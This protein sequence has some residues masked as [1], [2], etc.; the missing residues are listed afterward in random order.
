M[1][2]RH[3]AAVARMAWA[4]RTYPPE[5]L[6]GVLAATST[7]FDL[8]VFELFVPLCLGGTAI[9][10]D[11][12]LALPDLPAAGAV[13]LINTVPSA[14]AELARAGAVPGSVRV[15]NLA[16]E[17]LPPEL[18]A[19]LYAL[20][21]IEEVHNLYGPSE[22]TTYS[23]GERV[24]RDVPA[25]AARLAIGRPLDNSRAWVLDAR[26]HPLPAG[27]PGELWLGGEG[28][29]RGYLR[30]PD[31]TADRF[32]PDPFA[33]EPGARLYRT[34]DLARRLPDGRLDFLGR[35]DHQ[36]KVRGFRI[37]LGEIET[38]LAAHPGVAEVAVAAW[39]GGIG[40]AGKSLAAYVVPLPGLAVDAAVLRDHL[41]ERLPAF[42]LPAS[43]TALETLPRTANGKLDRKALPRPEAA[44]PA[45]GGDAPRNPLEELIAA[46]W[47]DLLGR[48]A[49]GIH[50]D[51]FALGGHS[52][53]ATRVVSRLRAELGVELPLRSLFETPTVAGL[54]GRAEAARGGAAS[55]APPLERSPCA[56]DLPLSFAQERL[57]LLDRITPGDPAYNVPLAALCSGPLDPRALAA[58]CGEVVR[59]HEVLRTVFRDGEEGPAQEVRPAAPFSL[60]VIDLAALPAAEREPAALLLAAGEALL[61]FD[62]ARGPMF[63]ASLLHLGAEEHALL[64]T[65][66]HAAADGWSLRVLL[67]ELSALYAARLAGEPSPLPELPLQY[68]DY[69]V[70]QRRWL[71]GAPLDAQLAWWRERLQ[72]PPPPL[73][74]PMACP[75]ESAGRPRG[76]SADLWLSA[77]AAGA[78]RDLGRR[79]GATTFMTLMAALQALLARYTGQTDLCVGAPVAGRTRAETEGLIGLFLNTLA[80]RGDLTGDPTFLTLL[81]RVREATL[82]AY[83]HQ[84]L[85]FEKLVEELQPRR[86][87]RAA[88]LFQ[89]LLNALNFEAGGTGL[90]GALGLAGARVRRLEVPDATAKLDLTLY[91]AEVAEGIAL[92]FQYDASLLAAAQVERMAEHLRTLLDEVARDPGLHL[93]EIP[94][95]PGREPAR[96]LSPVPTPAGWREI[97]P[98]FLAGTIHGRFEEQAAASPDA[99]AIETAD[100]V[101][102]Y[103]DL[104]QASDRAAARIAAAGGGPVVALLLAHG[105]SMVAAML[106]ALKAGAVYVPLDPSFPR[107]RLAAILGDCGAGAILADALH[108]D[109]AR[110]LAAAA[111]ARVIA[112]EDGTATAPPVPAP[113]VPPEAPAYILY[114]SGSTGEPKGVVQSHRNVLHHIRAYVNALRLGPG[115]RL[116]LLASHAF[117]A[118]VMDVYGALL[119]GAA[120][121]P[122]DVRG[123]GT[124][125]VAAWLRR[126]AIT[127]YHSTPT[128]YR[129]VMEAVE[130]EAADVPFPAARLVVLGGERTLAHDLARFRR[131]FPPGA[132]FVNGLGP[133][134]STLALQFFATAEDAVERGTVPVGLPVAD[135]GVSLWNGA[136]EQVATYGVGEIALRGDHLALGYWRR[137]DLTAAAF[138][139][140]PAGEGARAYSTGDLARRL[141]DGNLEFAGRADFQVKVRGQ[142]VELGEIEGALG[143]LSG[144]REAVVVAREDAAGD[145]RL[146]AYLLV[147]EAAAP[148]APAELRRELRLRLPDAM[149]PAD[150][151]PLTAWPLT[152]TGKVDRGALPAPPPEDRSASAVA[153]E[154]APRS[155]AEELLARLWAEVLGVERVGIHDDFFALGGHSLLATQVLSRVRRTLGVEIPLRAVFEAATVAGLAERVNDALRGGALAP[156]ALD[157]LPRPF[158]GGAPLSFAQERLWFLDRL[159]PGSAAYNMPA[160]LRLAGDLD[161]PALQG[162][163]GAIVARHEVLRA[164]FAEVEGAPAQ[165]I[166]PVGGLPL[167]ALDL[168]GLPAARRESEA[169]RLAREE[170]RRPFD[171]ARGP[172]VRARLLRLGEREHLLLLV[173]HHIAGDG[174]SLGVLARE[175]A[176]LY[177][178]LARGEASPLPPLPIQFADFAAWQRAWL[179]GGELER[180]LAWWRERLAGAPAALEL[181]ADRPRPVRLSPRNGSQPL[182]LPAAL[183]ARLRQAGQREGSTLFMVLLAAFQAWLHRL[184]GEEDL[185]VGAPIAGRTRV[186]AEDL[187]GP[188][189]NTLVLRGDLA[190]DPPFRELLARTRE[191]ALAAHAHQDLPFERLVAELRPERALGQ[192]PLF[193]V[194]LVLQ[195]APGGPLRLPDL[196][197]QA[198]PL[199]SGGAKLDLSL[200]ATVDADGGLAGLIEYAADLFDAPTVARLGGHLATLL[201]GAAGRPEL[202]L[203]ALPLL[204]AEE[205]HQLLIE[206]GD[207]AAADDRDGLCLHAILAARAARHP[208]AVAVVS[209]RGELTYGE[210]WD[211]SARLAAFLAARGIG[212][213]SFV[214]LLMDSG[215]GLVVAMLAAMRAGAAFVPLDVEW[216]AARLAAVLEETAGRSGGVVLVDAASPEPPA[217]VPVRVDREAASGPV[218]S[219]A[220]FAA[221]AAD[222]EL[223]LYAI[224]TSGSTGRPKGVVV[225]H[226]G[227]VNRF[228]WME[229]A[230]GAAAA[231]AVLQTT[232]P[233]YDSAVW[234]IFWPLTLGGRTV[235]NPS[236]QGLDPDSVAGLIERHRITMTDFVPAVF[237]RVVERLAAGDEPAARLASLRAVVVGGEEMEPGAAREF[238]RRFPGVHLVN[239]YGPTEASIGCICHPVGEAAGARVPIGRPISNVAALVLDPRGHA[240]PA[241]VPGE[242]SVAGRCVGLGYLGDP[243][244]TGRSFVPNPFAGGVDRARMYRTGDRARWRAD[245]SLE[246]L[247]RIDRQIKIRGVRIEPGEIEAVLREHPW[248]TA[249]AVAPVA[250]AGELRLAAFVTGATESAAPELLGFLRDRLPR[251]LVPAAVVV[252][253]ALPLTPAGKVDRRALARLAPGLDAARP[254]GE[255]VAP[256]TPAEETLA[257]IWAEVLPPARPG[258]AVAIGVFDDF[259]ALGGHSLLALQ[260]ISRVRRAFGVELPVRDLFEAPTVAGLARRLQEEI[261]AGEGGAPPPLVPVGRERELPLSFAQ[262][263]LWFL[264]SLAPDSAL[265]QL[266]LAVRLSGPLD[267]TILARALGAVARRHES[268][269]TAFPAVDGGPVQAVAPAG[270][271]PLPRVDLTGLPAAGREGEA[272][273][274]AER[275]ARR[276]FDLARGPLL[277]ALLL[278]LGEAEHALLV[279]V[280]HTVCDGWSIGLLERELADLYA[281]CS[282]G[283]E[284][285]L[286]ELPVQYADYAVWQREWLAGEVLARKLDGWRRRLEGMPPV[287]ELPADRPRP[288]VQTFRGGRLPVALPAATTAALRAFGRSQGSTPFMTLL[289]GFAALLQRQTGAERLPVG[290]PVANRSAVE[291]ERL[292]GNFANT[293][294]LPL[295]LAGA[296]SF[297]ELAGRVRDAALTAFAHQ[298]LPFELLVESLA[299]RRDLSHNPVF[300]VLFGLHAFPARPARLGALEL[301]PFPVPHGAA[302]FD[303]ALDLVETPEGV[304]GGFE[305]AADLFDAATVARL[306]RHLLTLLEGALEAPEARLPELPVLTRPERQQL[307]REW[308]DTGADEIS[309]RCLHELVE[310]WAERAPE[311]EAVVCGEVRLTYGELDRR[312]DALARTLRGLGVGPEV[313]VGVYV[314]R[315][316]EMVVGLLGILKAGGAYLPLDPAYPAQRLARIL[317]DAAPPVVVTRGGLEAGLPASSARVVRL[318][319]PGAGGGRPRRSRRSREVTPANLAYVIY[320]SGST[321]RPKGVEITHRS[322]VHLME[323]ARRRFGF[324]ERDVWTVFHSFAFDFSVWEIWSALALGGRLVVVP[325]ETAQSPGRFRELLVAERV[326]VLNQT[327]SAVRQ[328]AGPDAAP[329]P[330]LRFLV[331]G[332]EAFP[333]ELAARLLDWGAPVWNFYGPTEAT[334]WSSAARITAAPGAEGVATL[335]RP[336]P[337]YRLHALDAGGRPVPVGVPGELHVAGAGLARGYARD[338]LLTAE[339]FVPDPFAGAPG[340]RLYRTGDLVR[341]RPD[342]EVEFLGRIDHQVKLR[343]FRIELGEI[344]AALASHPAVAEAAVLLREEPAGRRLVAYLGAREGAAPAAPELRAWLR[345]RVPEYMVPAAFVTLAALPLSPNGKVDRRALAAIAPATPSAAGGW[346]PP[347]TPVEE[348]LA[349]IWAEV[350]NVERVGVHDGFFDLGGHSLLATRMVSRAARLL[351][352]D[353]PLRAVFEAP[354][355]AEL[356]AVAEQR[357]KGGAADPPPI[358]R[359]SREHPLPLSFAQQRL[360]LLDR[361]EP[362]SSAYNV[363]AALRFRGPLDDRAFAAA[364]AEVVR[365]HEALRATFHEREGE[366][367]QQFAPFSGFP[368]AA[369]DLTAVPPARREAELLRLAG[370]EALR[371]FDLRK[372]PLL[373]AVLLRLDRDERALLLTLHHIAGDGWSLEVLVR[374]LAAL[375]GAAVAGEPSRLPELPVQYADFALWQR[376]QLQGA[377]LESQ[378]AWWRERFRELP[379]PLE[380][381]AARS[382]SGERSRQGAR[383]F[384]RLPAGLVRALRDLG[385]REGATLFM[386]LLAGLEA[387]LARYT[388]QT[389]LCVGTPVAGRTR[390]ETEAL[391]GVFLN[392]LALRSDLAGDP[393]FWELLARVRETTLGAYAHQDLP[394]E[395]LLAALRPARDLDRAPLFQVLFNMLA[396]GA[397]AQPSLPGI[398]LT[399]I[400]LPPLAPKFD[401]TVYA[402]ERGEEIE[403][404]LHYDGELFEARQMERMADHLRA[405]LAAAAADPELTLSGLPLARPEARPVFLP[406][407]EAP[408]ESIPERFAAVARAHAG[409]PAVV[410]AGEEWT[411]ARL[412]GESDAVARS[413]LAALGPGPGRVALLFSPDAAMVAALLGALKAGWTYVP[414][415]PT[416]PERRLAFMLGDAGAA[417]VLTAP[418]HRDL[419]RSLAGALAGERIAVLE[420][421]DPATFAAPLPTIPPLPSLPPDTPAYILYTSGSTGEPK[422]VV[423]SHRNVLHHARTYADSLHLAPADRLSLL[424]SYSFDAAVMDLFGALLHGAALCPFDVRSEGI[425]PLPAWLAERRITVYHSTPTLF[426]ALTDAA[427]ERAFPAV[428]QVV[429]GGEKCVRR[430]FERFR[431]HFP[432]ECRFVNGLGPTEST[433]ALQ[434]FAAAADEIGRDT[435]PVG[436][437]VAG[438]EVTLRNGAGE[439]VAVYGAGEIHLRGP[440]LALGYWRRPELTAAAFSGPD[441]QGWRTYRSGDIGRWLPDGVLEY[442]GRADSQIKIRGQRVELGE[443]E[444]RLNALPEIG[445]AVVAA[446]EGADGEPRLI[447]YVLAPGAEPPLVP[448]EI[449]RRLRE[450]LPEVMVPAAFVFLAAWPLTPTGKVDRAALPAPAE[451]PRGPE[452]GYASP[453][454][455][456]EEILCA[457]WSEVLDVRRVG[458]HD[459]FFDLGGHSLLATRL[460]FRIQQALRVELSLRALF[461]SSTVA[462]L[463][464]R[465]EGEQGGG[466]AVAP[467]D[468]LLRIDGEER[469]LPFPLTD[470][471]QAYWVGRLGALDL[472]NVATHRYFEIE[473]GSRRRALRARLAA[474]DRPPRHA[475][476]GLPPRRP[477]ADPPRGPAVP[478]RGAGPGAAGRPGRPGSGWRRAARGCPT[479]S[480]RPT[481]GR[482]SRSGRSCWTAG[483]G[484]HLRQLRLSDRRRLEH[485]APDPRAA[486]RSTGSPTRR[487]HRRWSCRSATTCWPR[488]RCARPR[489]T[490]RRS[491]TGGAAWPTC[492]RRRSCRWRR[493]RRRSRGRVFAPPQGGPRRRRLGPSAGAAACAPASP[494]RRCCSP[495]SPRCWRAW[496]K[497]PR[498]TLNLTLFNRL[499]LHPQVNALVGDFTSPRC[500]PSSAPPPTASS[501]APA[502]SSSS[503]GATSTIAT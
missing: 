160:A 69:A 468:A 37:E 409:R 23:T 331:C 114:T 487:R 233:I 218:P 444:G 138:R 84:D 64:L 249:A 242:L 265:Y 467:L 208:E 14:M 173:L 128:L 470:I 159:E 80:I 284:P 352:V 390:L 306:S 423:Q 327:P 379:P 237:N 460:L 169:A 435:V 402:A 39:D 318:D 251:S 350:L 181:P 216:P 141:P 146:T 411:Y 391:A 266:L 429:L 298:D 219:F 353:L 349:G 437:P 357:L 188:F 234:Q 226:R 79:H 35:L 280:H 41:R 60:P 246:F 78:L 247:G 82:G 190:G 118:A 133:T 282:R 300:Q 439:Q 401:L 316:A 191:A 105:A 203:S 488:W 356:A 485:P 119:S 351:G 359:V 95:E 7:G 336:L 92:R 310:A 497:M 183:A 93:S 371:P 322:A 360:W 466:E 77:P 106:G 443:I 43:W 290:T 155:P 51:F 392:T 473:A 489:G 283:E 313:P 347:R 421:G 345:E 286:P 149:V 395:Q 377:A 387:L 215:P 250:A 45:A 503:S 432:A 201:A 187:I 475:A 403:L 241:G 130:E 427:G 457:L 122:F 72:D 271:V 256:R 56:G 297:R 358:P 88:P 341:L 281:A 383:A 32:R 126:R 259:F 334:V 275:E 174:W 455:E 289:A 87:P 320:T 156:P 147:P 132:I 120:L 274:W 18:A 329:P 83:G 364:L 25:A 378:L 8:S 229:R 315:S 438:T 258:E 179:S 436:F 139:P 189:A 19:R 144:I 17:P 212:P 267:A 335:G 343:G 231:A 217:G 321:G 65:L 26:L 207:T 494:L 414:L 344:E 81:A 278:R 449:R 417:A 324:G 362:G 445:E 162:A 108:L 420:S 116:A 164:T 161:V 152:P 193:Q 197:I 406:A 277:R 172:L 176:A 302:R 192:S 373:R 62:L 63:R 482:C 59:R 419:A 70:W 199:A 154:P 303:L 382:R 498:F 145:V 464:A 365:R 500:W 238:R 273:R 272:R 239:L 346:L 425:A 30:R 101:W 222:P 367:V 269:R 462:G 182:T 393:P 396:F 472:G 260:V 288:A 484:P 490:S 257:G 244:K 412:D 317:E 279:N 125:P 91:V 308:N 483:Q 361:L 263:R 73:P 294:V 184:T 305:Y 13:T 394:F 465:I 374:E 28:L 135:T 33:G 61:P 6:A 103:R 323:I 198:V 453:R 21:G 474:A 175:V 177:P 136:G 413:L 90:E 407:I 397:G 68:A 209:A 314:E 424:A 115:D 296:P 140:D 157:P 49:V 235:L 34:G 96:R 214:P 493:A 46:A 363:P 123:E 375:Y 430:D 48:E 477:P 447:A 15:V 89:V 326:T 491:S 254:D 57:W 461:E 372:G 261:A 292:I 213:G 434:H 338:P 499:P 389:D 228:L 121:C 255:P 148:L 180:Q 205:R 469:D 31:L 355:L 380:L 16:G 143:A 124:A 381:P 221:V 253:P 481:A 385:R 337:G 113:A 319:E 66:H 433:L 454:T 471:Q 195:N 44:G 204:S 206:W 5:R 386:V 211:R 370:E 38:A 399:P 264:D 287:L 458:V 67:R 248:V 47:A 501:S 252:L 368:L 55:A 107:P 53:L 276:P 227:I 428:L 496:S 24:G 165:S 112:A 333:R 186:E 194:L 232:R 325:V 178:A 50:D 400:E 270:G 4:A 12:A 441:G 171:L 486:G 86:D 109:L 200:S 220:A 230:F 117:D 340:G 76:A 440:H 131:R 426:R 42:M 99:P 167:P 196:E 10:A 168:T 459:D 480:C 304:H 240:A 100:G 1:V 502:G 151:V 137:P 376:E 29:A 58:A 354:T 2:I 75:R 312:A 9:L 450:H 85:P 170:A 22:D 307:L 295:V 330:A 408:E 476:G 299:P 332:G 293:L 452:A 416:Y 415:D 129:R 410:V 369:A 185:C 301:A 223:P 342:G 20:P 104:S 384:V 422:G 102:S 236:R 27:V 285:V 142:R 52:L 153:G 328:L 311:A 479:R 268:L 11:D 163:L 111:G 348:I 495:P 431:R 94:L 36:V 110:E 405:L 451:E 54:A 442:V 40:D 463:A 478:G 398:A 388:G 210:L 134:E 127:V 339:R 71:R 74:L 404:Q 446:R 98:D 243:E 262:Q 291:T 309:G 448:A 225:P 202:P 456:L 366:P 492:R 150:F 166:A 418:E 3:A 158:A 224:Y 97:A 245:G